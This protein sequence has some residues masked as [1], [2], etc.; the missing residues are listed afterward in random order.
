MNVHH[1]ILVLLVCTLSSVKA[2]WRLCG[3]RQ[4]FSLLNVTEVEVFPSPIK[5][6]DTTHF[7]IIGSLTN[8]EIY[9]GT[10]QASVK[11][12]GFRVFKKQGHL[13]EQEGGPVN[14]P[15]L[16]GATSLDLEETMP[17]FLPPGRMIL[18]LQASRNDS[19][20]L[21]CVDIDLNGSGNKVMKRLK[22][23]SSLVEGTPFST[24]NTGSTLGSVI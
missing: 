3:G 20:P 2:D 6:G 16:P 7:Q 12:L 9:S 22:S 17:G 24:I 15:L 19:K 4:T 1:S 10:L 23:P 14:C 13:C 5:A 18:T 8:E 11:Y 21:F